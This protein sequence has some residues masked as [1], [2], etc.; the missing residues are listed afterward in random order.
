M[1]SFLLLSRPMCFGCKGK[2]I[3]IEPSL[4][5]KRYICDVTHLGPV[6]LAGPQKVPGFST[7]AFFYPLTMP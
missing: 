7:G 1:P 2:V 5:Y 3:H 4:S 6:A